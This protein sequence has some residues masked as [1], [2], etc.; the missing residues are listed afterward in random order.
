MLVGAGCNKGERSGSRAGGDSKLA[1]R[2]ARMSSPVPV[3]PGC[4]AALDGI[5]GIARE[6]R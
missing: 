2:R 5:A 3:K 4:S 6:S 1:I